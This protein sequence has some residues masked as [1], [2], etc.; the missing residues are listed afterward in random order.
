MCGITIFNQNNLKNDE[1]SNEQ[2]ID[3]IN[4]LVQK[5]G[6]DNT[7]IVCY[8]DITFIHNLLSITGNNNVQPFQ[9][10]NN[11]E[12]I[13]CLFN[14]EIY[15][16]EELAEDIISYKQSN[17]SITSDGHVIIPY[18]LK[19]GLKF[20]EYLDGEY[21]IVI[22][23]FKLNKIL[24]I[25]DTFATKP[26]FYQ[27]NQNDL[28][29]MI[30]SYQDS[31]KINHFNKPIKLPANTI[32]EIQMSTFTINKNKIHHFEYNQHK[33]SYDDWIEAFRKSIQKRINTKH[34]IYV[35]MSGGYDSGA[36]CC[37][38]NNINKE[39][40]TFTVNGKEDKNTIDNRLI[41]N[42]KHQSNN[43]NQSYRFNMNETVI[44]KY[45]DRNDNE[46]SNY[47]SKVLMNHDT[48]Y[49]VHKD[50]A[51]TGVSFISDIASNKGFRIT[52]SGQ[53]ADEILS[54]YGFN[55]QKKTWHSIFGGKYP[56]I[57][58]DD[59]INKWESFDDGI[60]KCLIMKEESIVGSYGIE[61]RYPFLDK[62]LV[63]EF[64]WLKP[65]LKNKY[66][67]APLHHYL[68]INNYPFKPNDKIG[69]NCLY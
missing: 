55:G 37:M 7:N 35:S 3:I 69:F 61:T 30:A 64:L 28:T 59:F 58:T 44:K 36:I 62:Q 68:T 43:D 25:S 5:R 33:D 19:Y 27:F 56:D 29:F 52:L 49:G 46:T 17:T 22:F 12:D 20:P 23:D 45:K 21:A 18:Y 57:L 40:T 38:L 15:N 60:N 6:P 16:Y 39:Y 41:I 51:S 50:R 14:G 53:G 32:I 1:I 4:R 11:D 47:E 2:S 26:L 10:L 31:L 67:K 34:K 24:L 63:Q 9:Y 66:Y 42:K 65:E 8:K 54:D 48:I 13:I